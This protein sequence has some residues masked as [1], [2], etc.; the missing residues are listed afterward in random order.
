MTVFVVDAEA[1][2]SEDLVWVPYPRMS[3][4]KDAD[5]ELED[6]L[7]DVGIGSETPPRPS[8]RPTQLV[9]SGSGS[10]VIGSGSGVRGSCKLRSG[11]D[12]VDALLSLVADVSG[13]ARAPLLPA[14]GA[15]ATHGGS[16]TPGAGGAAVSA[17]S[18]PP[19]DKCAYLCLGPAACAV[20]MTRTLAPPHRA[21]PSLRCLQCD[22]V[23]LQFRGDATG[24]AGS[25]GGDDGVAW[26]ASV[27]YLFLRNVYPSAHK[28]AARLAHRRGA[29]AYCCQCSWVTVHAEDGAAVVV[30]RPGGPVPLVAPPAVA[31]VGG[32]AAI[33]RGG[34]TG[35]SAW[36]HWVCAGGHREGV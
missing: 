13:A 19:V 30:R 32:A 34:R 25:G 1:D 21:C 28:L 35:G 7:R 17:N 33:V 36:T 27:D 18:A 5:A 11:G 8:P 31:D 22:F 29:A 14:G 9:G 16:S 4:S 24:G 15:A 10:G 3:S 12:D 23:V 26:A 20:G 2:D 6:L